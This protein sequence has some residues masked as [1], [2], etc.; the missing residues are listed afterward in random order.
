[1]KKRKNKGYPSYY[2]KNIAQNAQRRWI[3]KKNRQKKQKGSTKEKESD[4]MPKAY[5]G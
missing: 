5:E 1:M 4:S 2:G 3:K